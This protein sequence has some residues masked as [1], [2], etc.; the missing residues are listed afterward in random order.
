MPRIQTSQSQT[1]HIPVSG[2]TITHAAGFFV[3]LTFA[4]SSLVFREPPP[5][6]ILMM[7][8]I[9]LLPMARLVSV[10]PS[11]LFLL[12]AWLIITAAG[13]IAS[14][15]SMDMRTSTV[16]T[17]ITFY[18][19]I[20]SV[21][22]AS[23][24]QH[25]PAKHIMLVMS[26]YLVAAPSIDLCPADE[27]YHDVVDSYFAR[28]RVKPGITGWAQINGWR[29]ETD[30]SEKIQRRVEHDLYYIENWSVL[31]DLSILLKT[32]FSLFDTKQA[33]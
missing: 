19:G 8:L 24:I 5:F 1:Q 2:F 32:P 18:L 6:D 13:L 33:Y 16:H 7:G 25:N 4:L 26:G 30:T 9:V 29:G 14:M 22:L 17:L 11:I 12:G 28:H 31:F 23:F 3:W 27:L 15:I 10:T 21:L 20:V